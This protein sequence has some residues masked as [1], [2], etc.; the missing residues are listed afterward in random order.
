MY[1]VPYLLDFDFYYLDYP[2]LPFFAGC[3]PERAQ[4][5]CVADAQ[6]SAAY[7]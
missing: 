4:L 1:I 2:D 7:R 5:C 6:R 3:C